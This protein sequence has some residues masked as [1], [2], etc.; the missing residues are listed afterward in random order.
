MIQKTISFLAGK[1][2]DGRDSGRERWGQAVFNVKSSQK[3]KLKMKL[4]DLSIQGREG[5]RRYKVPAIFVVVKKVECVGG[6][7]VRERE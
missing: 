5:A 7:K 6:R 1:M 2:L 4:L 3:K